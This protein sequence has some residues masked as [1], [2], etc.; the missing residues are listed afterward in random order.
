MLRGLASSRRAVMASG[1]RPRFAVSI[2]L[3]DRIA[4][5]HRTS[6]ATGA[7]AT[8]PQCRK[9]DD[10]SDATNLFHCGGLF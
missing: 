2:S 5:F 6:E 7:A 3:D 1:W 10:L 4:G 9:F 8:T